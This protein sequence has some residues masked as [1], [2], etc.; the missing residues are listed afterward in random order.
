MDESDIKRIATEAADMAARKAI[1]ETLVALGVDPDRPFEFQERMNF[2]KTLQSAS[3][4]AGRQAITAM[5]GTVIL[6]V[7]WA[8]WLQVGGN[9]K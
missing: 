5:I 1:R 9:G 2:L 8:I 3:N 4:A 6:G 7:L